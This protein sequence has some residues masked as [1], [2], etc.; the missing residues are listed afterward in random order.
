MLAAMVTMELMFAFTKRE[1]IGITFMSVMVGFFA[2]AIFAILTE[3]EKPK[4][5]RWETEDGLDVMVMSTKGRG[6]RH[7]RNH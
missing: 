6:K 2:L 5:A 3:P 1:I 7:A 4:K